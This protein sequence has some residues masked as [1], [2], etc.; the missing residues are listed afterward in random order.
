MCFQTR[1]SLRISYIRVIADYSITF[2]LKFSFLLLSS[3]ILCSQVRKRKRDVIRKICDVGYVTLLLF[4]PL[5]TLH[6]SDVNK[7]LK[8][9]K[10]FLGMSA[11]CLQNHIWP[12]Y[13]SSSTDFNE[14][15]L[16]CKL[17]ALYINSWVQHR[18]NSLNSWKCLIPG[19]FVS[20]LRTW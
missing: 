7:K 15:K 6:S 3:F 4:A 16:C 11:L 2:K 10:L 19:H 12:I 17:D 14:K 20:I 8:K 9:K 5:L 18:K 13:W 1:I